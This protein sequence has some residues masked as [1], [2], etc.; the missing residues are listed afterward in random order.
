MAQYDPSLRRETWLFKEIGRQGKKNPI[1]KRLGYILV[2]YDG[3]P[4]HY[5]EPCPV[6][7]TVAVIA[8]DGTTTGNGCRVI[9]P[10]A[11]G[12][13]RMSAQQFFTGRPFE[14]FAY[15]DVDAAGNL[16]QLP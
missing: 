11:D 1:Y 13:G 5:L 7:Q 3:D 8:N 10:V 15:N 2:S 6:D 16:G 12:L 4:V 9:D 14:V